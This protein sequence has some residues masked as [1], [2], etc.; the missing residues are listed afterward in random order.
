MAELSNEPR[1]PMKRRRM[2][3]RP[4]INWLARPPISYGH[5]GQVEPGG[6]KMELISCD[7][8]EMVDHRSPQVYLGY[9]NVLKLDRSVY[10]SSH[11]RVNMLMR[12]A[13]TTPFCIDKLHII[14]PEN[15][16]DA[17]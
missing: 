10:C 9:Q 8:G 15:G 16:F 12:H 5:Y 17:P 13:D 1:R 4:T 3:G 7:G 11:E 6:L 14:A 2:T